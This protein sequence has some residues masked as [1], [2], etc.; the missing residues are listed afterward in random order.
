M[1][2]RSGAARNIGE[3]CDTKEKAVMI[4]RLEQMTPAPEGMFPRCICRSRM[5][6]CGSS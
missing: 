1:I 4:G 5:P 3:A 2:A 6:T